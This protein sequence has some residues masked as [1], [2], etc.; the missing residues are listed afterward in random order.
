[1]PILYLAGTLIAALL[2]RRT[3]A[4]AISFALWIVA[5]VM[6]G[7]GPAT[8]SSIDTGSVGFWGP[9]AIVLVVGLAL[10][11]VVSTVRRRRRLRAA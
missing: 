5:V 8:N 2:A 9:W 1:M 4:Y 3:T 10:V 11:T 6:V 7:W